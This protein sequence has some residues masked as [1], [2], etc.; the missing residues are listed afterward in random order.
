MKL[1]LV[2]RRRQLKNRSELSPW[3]M[4]F[5]GISV[6]RMVSLPL[7][8]SPAHSTT[9][10]HLELFTKQWPRLLLS[11]FP[12]NKRRGNSRV[13]HWINLFTNGFQS[14]FD[15]E[16]T[17]FQI[18]I[19]FPEIIG[20]IFWNNYS[21]LWNPLR[22][23]STRNKLP[24]IIIQSN[25]NLLLFLSK[26]CLKTATYGFVEIYSEFLIETWK[27]QQIHQHESDLMIRSLHAFSRKA[28]SHRMSVK[29][30]S[31]AKSINFLKAANFD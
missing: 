29:M 11:L 9:N 27:R 8:T 10:L 30:I 2:N 5:D 31:V 1:D 23:N 28:E 18:S 19:E 3:P 14:T 12:W 7:N 4:N 26:N 15:H 24:I 21:K 20:L 22:I 25:M 16:N 6:W 13:I 17:C